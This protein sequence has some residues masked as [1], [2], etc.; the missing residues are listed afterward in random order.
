MKYNADHHKYVLVGALFVIIAVVFVWVHHMTSILAWSTPLGWG[1]DAWSVLAI[2]KAFMDGDISLIL[3][4][5]VSHLNAPFFAN[6]NDFPIT[7]EVIYAAIGWL[8]RLIGLFAAANV[9]LLLAS[10]LAGYSFWFVCKELKYKSSYSLSAAVLFAFSHYIF[11]R[12]LNHIALSYYWH[13]PLMFYVSW[14]LLS[15]RVVQFRTRDWWI[16]IF[17]AF[18]SGL[19][20]PYY[21]GMFVQLLGFVV[22]AHLIRRQF[23]M[24]I[25]P[26]SLIV[27]SCLVFLVMN[28]DTILYAWR[29]GANLEAVTRNF[30]GL[31]VFALKIPGLMFPPAYHRWHAW[32]TYAQ[33]NYFNVSYIT[34]EDWSPYL[35]MVGLV[36]L[37][38]LVGHA[39][40]RVLQGR[41]ELVPVHAWQL[42]WILLFSL[43]GGVNLLLGSFGILFFRGTNRY[44]IFILA[45]S[46]LFLVRQL[47]KYQLG[48]F[49]T[50]LAIIMLVVGLWDQLPPRATMQDVDNVHRQIVSDRAFTEGIERAV[51]IGTMVFQLPVM[52]YPESTPIEGMSDYEHFRPYLFSKALRFSY[53]TIK[54]RGDGV[55]Q[56]AI[57]KLEPKEM[58]SA[59]EGYGFGVILVNKKAYHDRG[60]FLVQGFLAGGGRRLAENGDMVAIR[61]R[62]VDEPIL[63][64]KGA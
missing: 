51:P 54:G 9:I 37:I 2:S 3:S 57:G 21:M 48:R 41:A 11:A 16:A 4:K 32:A 22:A 7:E 59:L 53:G 61:I 36:G 29:Y 52:P 12:N 23:R 62:P 31:E 18:F 44:S 63:P 39:T 64:T 6:W 28:A 20:N 33:Q 40:Y 13:V 38:W 10:I 60:A 25:L 30:A 26:M 8:G 50:A 17:T 19:F 47:S 1:G 43:V 27:I 46:L 56:V 34:G 15:P 14:R 42:N 24:V 35:G 45:L 49:S 5:T 58:V 55:W